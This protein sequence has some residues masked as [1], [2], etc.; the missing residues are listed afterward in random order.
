M[1]SCSWYFLCFNFVTNCTGISL[2]SFLRAGCL[3]RYLSFIPGMGFLCNFFTRRQLCITF[4]AVGISCVAF[5]CAGRSFYIAQLCVYMPS[6]SW[7]F[8]CF[9]FVTNC[10][11][12]GFDSRF[13]ASC[14]LCNFSTIPHMTC[15]FYF[16]RITCFTSCTSINPFPIY[17]T[18]SRCGDHSSIILMFKNKSHCN[19]SLIMVFVSFNSY[20]NIYITCCFSCYYTISINLCYIFLL[21]LIRNISYSGDT[22]I[23]FF[24]IWY[25]FSIH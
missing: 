16:F 4:L 13:F 18:T 3:C 7:Y 10:T 17:F 25:S 20:Q 11:R 9:N 12:I 14:I 6:C 5:F 24:T 19:L 15:C 23:Y 2:N 21:Y 22:Q 8:L 1:L